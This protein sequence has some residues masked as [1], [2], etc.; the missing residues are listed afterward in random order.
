MNQLRVILLAFIS[1]GQAFARILIKPKVFVAL[2]L[3]WT[4]AIAAHAVLCHKFDKEAMVRATAIRASWRMKP[5]GF[6]GF[7]MGTPGSG[8]SVG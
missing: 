7:L 8:E 3:L 5:A 2:L 4:T 1:P 6:G